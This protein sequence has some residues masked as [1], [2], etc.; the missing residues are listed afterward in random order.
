LFLIGAQ[1]AGTTQL[2]TLLGQHPDVCLANPK[3]PSYFSQFWGVRDLQWYRQRFPD[4]SA[5]WL[6]DG[7]TSYSCARL[8]EYDGK[9]L[10]GPYAEVPSR[11]A[12]VAE[13]PRFLYI[14]RDP[15]G[16]THSSYWH[17]VR[18]GWEKRPFDRAVREDSFYL[19][20]GAY[21][22]QLRVYLDVFPVDSFHF[23]FFEDFRQDPIGV[24]RG[25][26]RFLEI[27]PDAELA[28]S[29]GRNRS[30]RYSGVARI[31]D[32]LLIPFGGFREVSRRTSA[33]APRSVKRLA[34]RILTRKVPPLT[35]EQRAFLRKH[36]EPLDREIEELVGR[37]VPWG[38]STEAKATAPVRSSART[39][40]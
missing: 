10:D 35:D 8:P 9:N 7:S 17:A 34:E 32:R 30:F 25:C 1:K 16:R 19:R 15:V 2:A 18:G 40:A 33:I 12:S 6:L 21:A 4:T 23:L 20:T 29:G 38:D 26:L 31:L 14:M 13:E 11:I 27:D 37:R 24:T 3:E 22:R 36:F 5:S 39:D 28:V